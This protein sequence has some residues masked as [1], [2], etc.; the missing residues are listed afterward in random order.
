MPHKEHDASHQCQAI[1]RPLIVNGTLRQ[2]IHR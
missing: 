1:I 2:T